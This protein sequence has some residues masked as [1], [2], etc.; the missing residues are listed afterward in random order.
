MPKFF[1]N[2]DL[3]KNSLK[4]AAIDPQPSGVPN[5][6]SV[7]QIYFDT[8]GTNTN[9]YNRLVIRNAANDAW[10]N[11]PYSGNIRNAD[12][13]NS[14]IQI[15]KIDTSSVKLNTIGAPTA[16]VDFNGQN[17]TG[18]ANPRNGQPQDAA[19]KAYVDAAVSNLNVHA[20]ANVTTTT[21]LGGTYNSGSKTLTVTS[22]G[23]TIDGYT[24]VDT[25]R[26]LVKNQT[27][28]SENGIYT[29]SINGSTLTLTRASDYNN[30]TSGEIAPGD[31]V[32]VL[33]GGQ[34]GNSYTM[35]NT[36]F[37]TLDAVGTTGAIT[38]TQFGQVTNYTAGNG[39]SLNSSNQFS[40][41]TN[42]VPTISGNKTLTFTVS[43]NTSLTLPTSGTL[44]NN[45]VTTL[46]SLA[47]IGTITT[48]TWNGTKIGIPYGGTGVDASSY[49]ATGT[50]LAGNGTGAAPT[51]RALTST[52]VGATKKYA[53]QI[54]AT[55]TSAITVTHSLNTTDVV[56]QVYETSGTGT[57]STNL[58]YTDTAVTSANAV[59][60]TFGT[61]DNLYYRVVVI[62]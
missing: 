37:T 25:N 27:T 42:I 21:D 32:L 45:A 28:T 15:G 10:L 35:S 2:I 38:W 17:I 23:G 51:W 13:V 56:V 20:P 60:V 39:L 31:Y 53:T 36:S 52:E 40:V 6:P 24:V 16:S 44:V 46:S 8:N 59:T 11:I 57:A 18:L 54:Q 30:D 55:T 47:S 62:G 43:D 5:S 50:V 29:A 4:N 9:T 1:T 41:D 12:L 3:N 48:G 22:F 19:T 58:V 26:V 49:P 34:K 61:A 14:T 7:G 33:G